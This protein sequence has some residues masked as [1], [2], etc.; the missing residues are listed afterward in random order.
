MQ[1]RDEIR[2]TLKL[3][4]EL[5]GT[6]LLLKMKEKSNRNCML[7]GSNPALLDFCIDNLLS[8]F[9]NYNNKDDCELILIDCSS[10]S[11]I[12][13]YRCNQYYSYNEW[14]S[15][16]N[17]PRIDYNDVYGFFEKLR[18]LSED[19]FL[20]LKDNDLRSYKSYNGLGQY[21][22]KLKFIC[23]VV[24]NFNKLKYSCNESGWY[25]LAYRVQSLCAYAMATGIHVVLSGVDL[26]HDILDILRMKVDTTIFFKSDK[27]V[28]SQ[29]YL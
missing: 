14:H 11:Q 16:L 12:K 27:S 29:F 20:F 19:R 23:V 24:R 6:E 22:G 7:L 26:E 2:C 15:S 4:T 1:D 10:K 13:P 18:I 25:N 5:D 28:Y 21:N 9:W 3:G 8:T 17:T